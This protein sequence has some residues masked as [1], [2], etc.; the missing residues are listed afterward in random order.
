MSF[1]ASPNERGLPGSHRVDHHARVPR[2]RWQ[3][4]QRPYELWTGTT[5]S[6]VGDHGVDRLS[7]MLPQHRFLGCD[8]RPVGGPPRSLARPFEY[9]E[10]AVGRISKPDA[11]IAGCPFALHILGNA[12][13]VGGNDFAQVLRVHAGREGCRV[14]A[15]RCAYCPRPS[16][17]S[18]SVLVYFGYPQAHEDDAERAVRAGAGGQNQPSGAIFGA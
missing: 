1:N 17:P 10:G 2:A 12:L 13:L 9:L 4:W 6:A 16:F 18:Q 11:G 3:A 7:L 8:A 15:K 14:S 5:R